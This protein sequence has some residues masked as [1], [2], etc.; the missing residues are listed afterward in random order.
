MQ[1]AALLFSGMALIVAVRVQKRQPELIAKQIA[2]LDRGARERNAARVIAQLTREV[3]GEGRLTR[4]SIRVTNEGPAE[5]REI[6]MR[7]PDG[8]SP[9]REGEAKRELPIPVLQPGTSVD[10]TAAISFDT[11]PPFHAELVWRDGLGD[12]S[13][14]T[15]LA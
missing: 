1:W 13:T 8:G 3:V 10:I 12:H 9:V 15:T 2:A 5:A 14:D 6:D 11:V 4:F 7:F